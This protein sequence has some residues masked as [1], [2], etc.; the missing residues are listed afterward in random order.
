MCLHL[1]EHW[2]AEIKQ[3][4][5]RCASIHPASLISLRRSET[6]YIY[7][8]VMQILR[9]KIKK[10][11][12]KTGSKCNK[13][14]VKNDQQVNCITVNLIPKSV[15][16]KHTHLARLTQRSVLTHISPDFVTTNSVRFSPKSHSFHIVETVSAVL[17]TKYCLNGYQ[18]VT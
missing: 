4:R 18:D 15:H 2:N 5:R 1:S 16:L 14:Q 10:T 3:K 13:S 8:F 7:I 12:D 6:F 11:R 17:S 9:L